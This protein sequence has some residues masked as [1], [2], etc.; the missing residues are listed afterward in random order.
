M[1][2]VLFILGELTDEDIDWL[3]Y[4]G[5]REQIETD[6]ILIYEGQPID[7]LYIVLKGLLS[8]SVKALGDQEIAQLG[9]GEVV[10]EM[11][12][13]DARLPSATVKASQPTL[14]L[15]IPWQQ[16][17]RKLSND[18]GFASRF[19]RALAFSLSDRLRITVGHLGYGKESSH[20]SQ[21]STDLEDLNPHVL[22]NLDLAVARFD[23]LVRRLRGGYR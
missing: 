14:V 7:A 19:Y 15:S 2:K 5:R 18:L 10:G 1:K 16:L 4:V 6:T 23:A 3:I 21:G 8:V 22:E 17:N 9:T 12:F 11:S 20:S 13:V